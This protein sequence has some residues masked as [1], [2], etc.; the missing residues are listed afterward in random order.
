MRE[1]QALT[2]EVRPRYQKAAREEKKAIL[3]E[4]LE[5]TGYNRKYALRVLNERPAK[6]LL[7]V[8]GGKAVRIKPEKKRRKKRAGRKVY[9][10][11]VIASLRLIWIFF[12]NKCGKILAPLMREQMEYIAE[13]PAFKIRAEIREKLE[14]IS[15]ATIDRALKKDRDAMK[16]KG[17]SLTKKPET[18]KNRIPIRTFYTREERQTPGYMQVDSVHHCGAST[19]GEYLLTMT[20]TDVFSGWVELRILPNK[21]WRWSFEALK[22][23][24]AG[25]PFQFLEYHSDNGGEFLNGAVEAWCKSEHVPFTRSR[26]HHSNDNQFV[27]QKNDK[28]VREYIGYAR[29]TGPLMLDLVREVYKNLIPFLDYVLPTAKLKEKVRI[30]SKEKRTHDKPRSPYARLMESDAVPQEVKG[31]LKKNCLLYN[32]VVLQDNINKAVDRLNRAVAEISAGHPSS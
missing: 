14:K 18:M 15:P 31:V 26:D 2:R 4:Y 11:D 24:R 23:I 9:T 30:G 21:A 6:E 5:N 10:E 32:P 12:W 19:G 25:L 1:K 13:W 3:A 22:D 20:A 17:K 16:V 7:L 8:R 29:M 27:E 28:A